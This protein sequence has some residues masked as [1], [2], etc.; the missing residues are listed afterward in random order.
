MKIRFQISL[1]GATKK[2]V[3]EKSPGL[4][5]GTFCFKPAPLEVMPET[6]DGR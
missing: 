3:D 5:S 4:P 1:G 6:D 2:S